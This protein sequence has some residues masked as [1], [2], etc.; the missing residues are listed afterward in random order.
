MTP[1]D[2]TPEPADDDAAA[3]ARYGEQL[4][5]ALVAALPGWVDRCIR[6]RLVAPPTEAQLARIAD[7]QAAAVEAVAEPLF[8]LVRAPLA[9][10]RSNPLAVARR[11]AR[12]PTDVLADLGV[13]IVVRDPFDARILPD[14]VYALSP[15]TFA[16]IDPELA[17]IGIVW[18]AA[19]AHVHLRSRAAKEQ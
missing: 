1:M 3:F 13:P 8:A 9:R 18:G 14:D 2:A 17:E 10:Q 7:A 12:F 5:E 4:A 15:A 19:K 11:A 6:R 16:D